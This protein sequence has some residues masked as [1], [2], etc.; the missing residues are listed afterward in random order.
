MLTLFQS[1]TDPL[2]LNLLDQTWIHAFSK[3]NFSDRHQQIMGRF[4]VRYECNN[5]RD[6]FRLQHVHEAKKNG[7]HRIGGQFI[8]ELNHKAWAAEKLDSR[9]DN[10]TRINH[11]FDPMEQSQK[12]FNASLARG[13]M[14]HAL[15]S[16]GWVNPD[17][18]SGS[19]SEKGLDDQ[20]LS[21]SD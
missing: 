7:F 21:D 5:T 20:Q 10:I 17:F 1:W 4:H 12:M 2:S 9:G 6:N 16:A 8:H 18:E 3:H 15:E 19:P 14:K 11:D 13:A